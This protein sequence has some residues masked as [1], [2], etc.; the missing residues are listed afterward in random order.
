[1]A[2]AKA[3]LAAREATAEIPVEMVL[4][5]AKA[6]SSEVVGVVGVRALEAVEMATAAMDRV[7]RAL[8]RLDSALVGTV[9]V[10]PLAEELHAAP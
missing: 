1:M 7:D 8:A 3:T 10:A 6:A 4:A 9:Q 5:V 2:V